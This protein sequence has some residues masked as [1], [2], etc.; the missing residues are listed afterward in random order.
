MLCDLL[1]ELLGWPDKW[2]SLGYGLF[3]SGREELSYGL[4]LLQ[5]RALLT[6]IYEIRENSSFQPAFSNK[7]FSSSCSCWPRTFLVFAICSRRWGAGSRFRK[8]PPIRSE[9][10]M[11]RMRMLCYVWHRMRLWV[12]V[13]WRGRA[14]TMMWCGRRPSGVWTG[15]CR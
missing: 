10:T 9:F 6:V 1:V 13:M 8:V 14:T 15:L 12:S 4:T 7:P 11:W 3:K 2:V 5:Q